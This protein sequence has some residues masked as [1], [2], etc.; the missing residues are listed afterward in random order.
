MTNIIRK[1]QEKNGAA[2]ALIP[3]VAWN[4]M[5]VMFRNICIACNPW[6]RTTIVLMDDIFINN[7]NKLKMEI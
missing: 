2:N 4:G 7:C 3:C 1:N 5:P 6:H